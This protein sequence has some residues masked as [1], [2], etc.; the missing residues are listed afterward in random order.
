MGPAS[1][2]GDRMGSTHN[3]KKLDFFGETGTQ[4]PDAALISHEPG[5]WVVSETPTHTTASK[6]RDETSMNTLPH[7]ASTSAATAVG[8]ASH[9][10]TLKTSAFNGAGRERARFARTLRAAAVAALTGVA[11]LATPGA[12]TSTSLTGAI[13]AHSAAA[14]ATAV[15]PDTAVAP[16]MVAANAVASAY[17]DYSIIAH[18]GTY[19]SSSITENTIEAARHGIARGATAV[20]LDVMPTID[21]GLII[22]HDSTL[23]RTTTCTGYVRYRTLAGITTKCRGQQG[24]ERIPT[25]AQYLAWG[26]SAGANLYVEIKNNGKTWTP[27]LVDKVLAEIDNAGMADRVR[28][29]SY[30]INALEHVE[31]AR[32]EFLTTLVVDHGNSIAA[33]VKAA[34]HVDAFGMCAVDMT[35][36]NRALMDAA[37]IGRNG[38]LTDNVVNWSLMRQLGVRA[39]TVNSPSAYVGWEANGYSRTV[40]PK[41]THPC[42]QATNSVLG[43]VAP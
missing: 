39:V 42:P 31:A 40:G 14:P 10:S 24:G 19:G 7:A 35:P 29:L 4:S 1:R 3:Q 41:L 32:P 33:K 2:D 20:E 13:G 25:F 26:K 34:P 38:R 37:G 23:G 21:N 30:N 36:A 43:V 17:G 27:G 11:L 8:R 6:K 12:A 9:R 15:A 5:H 22:M 18:R 28:F 16:E